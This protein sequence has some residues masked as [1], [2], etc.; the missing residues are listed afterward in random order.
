MFIYKYATFATYILIINMY[1]YETIAT[2]VNLS[3]IQKFL[4]GLIDILINKSLAWQGLHGYTYV[5][6][7]FIRFTMVSKRTDTGE[8]EQY[9]TRKIIKTR[10]TKKKRKKRKNKKNIKKKY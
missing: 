9:R 5:Y 7:E 10:K 6:K 4:K 3:K 2:Y 1:T 8:P